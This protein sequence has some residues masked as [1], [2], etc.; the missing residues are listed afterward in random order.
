[1]YAHVIND[2]IDTVGR[3]P[4]GADADGQWLTLTEGNAHLAGWFPVVDTARPSD[5][6]DTTHDRAVELVNGTPT[7]V[8]TAR[9]WTPDELAARQ[10]SA[11]ATA[12][13]AAISAALAE[14]QQ[15]V[16]AP[17][18]PDVPAGTLT[19]AQLS[20]TM[21]A[22]RDVVQQNRAGIQRVA[23]TLKQTIRLVRGDFEGTD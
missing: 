17:A 10:Q 11:N 2:T 14:L 1:M 18:V 5:T 13:D 4:K 19:N 9:P 21:R 15:L 7:V 22:M 16:D 23:G 6:A 12:I 3:L 20:N 8:W